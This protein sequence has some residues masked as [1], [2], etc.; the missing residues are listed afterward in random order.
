[1][2]AGEPPGEPVIRVLRGNPDAAEVAALTAVLLGLAAT[3]RRHTG[4]DQHPDD[5]VAWHRAQWP[6]QAGGSWARRRIAGWSL[7]Q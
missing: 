3:S 7:D 1:M 4:P 5:G 6:Q 2:I